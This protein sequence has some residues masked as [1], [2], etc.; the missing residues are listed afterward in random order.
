MLLAFC[1][2]LPLQEFWK[3]AT[4]L[5]Y[6]L[7]WLANRLRA[8]SI[9]SHWGWWDALVVAWIGSAYLAAAF[10]G[11]DGSAWAKTGDVAKLALL[12]WLVMRSGYSARELRW[13]LG[14]LVVS[15]LIGLL[16]GYWR[17]WSGAGKSG[18]LQ[19]YS[20]GQVNHTAIYIAMMFGVCVSWLFARW[21]EWRPDLRMAAL[22]IT[23]FVFA[24]LVVTASRG[25]IG[26][27]MLLAVL[28][29]LA[30]WP[31]WRAPFAASAIAMAVAGVLLVGFGA[32]VVK[33]QAKDAAEENVLAFRDGIWRM[34][35]AAWEKYP[36]FGVGKDNYGL[37]THDL[38][39]S[40]RAEA[41]KDYD[42]SRYVRF[43]HAHNLYVNTLAERGIVG[44]AGLA[45]LLV[46]WLAALLRYRPR[47]EAEDSD[48][49]LWGGA[50]SAWIVTSGVGM[51]NTTFHHE[52]GLLAVLLLGLWLST[53]P[54]HRAS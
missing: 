23:V 14:A 53:L 2:F 41:G 27:G 30:W 11:L 37:I 31:R 43:P 15:N 49:L 33:K 26:V 3:S 22:A 50:A 52:H 5:A 44:F 39:R 35:F 4:L 10:A 9:G 19:L 47:P 40:W 29:A 16:H 12:L 17:M 42:P 13:V 36:W 25:A 1:I 54:A 20:V 48:W 18:N 8:G 24:S 6:L 45:A 28:L 46:A 7:V 51:V 38:V 34:G 32:E 21:R